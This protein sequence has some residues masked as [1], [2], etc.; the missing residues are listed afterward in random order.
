M[1]L[2]NF[3]SITCTCSALMKR[4]LC[5]FPTLGSKAL[6]ITSNF[7]I[8]N[9]LSCLPCLCNWNS[10]RPDSP[11]RGICWR[12]FNGFGLI[13]QKFSFFCSIIFLYGVGWICN[14]MWYQSQRMF[15]VNRLDVQQKSTFSISLAFLSSLQPQI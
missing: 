10:V 14:V 9:F 8:C 7:T 11:I 5:W 4:I 15:W 3:L 6:E 12:S 2:T 1:M 13:I